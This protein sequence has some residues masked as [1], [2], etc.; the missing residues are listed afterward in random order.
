MVENQTIRQLRISEEA[1]L[2]RP[3][4]LAEEEQTRQAR[5]I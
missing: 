5:S 4:N 2:I 1:N 3:E